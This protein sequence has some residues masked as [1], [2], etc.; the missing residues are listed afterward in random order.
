ME[1][2][3]TKIDR[4]K[5]LFISG[6]DQADLQPISDSFEP[7][8]NERNEMLYFQLTAGL[9]RQREQLKNGQRLIEFYQTAVIGQSLGDVA[10]VPGGFIF[11]GAVFV[12]NSADARRDVERRQ[13]EFDL[14]IKEASRGIAQNFDIYLAALESQDNDE[15]ALGYASEIRAVQSENREAAFGLAF[16]IAKDA[17]LSVGEG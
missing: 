4:W 8:P 1:T 15:V 10:R 16:Q 13:K 3:R 6:A 11:S 14:N 7:T 12:P 17:C 9:Y 5:H 2:N